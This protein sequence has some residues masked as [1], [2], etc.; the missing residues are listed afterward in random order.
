MVVKNIEHL[1]A[2]ACRLLENFLPVEGDEET[3]HRHGNDYGAALRYHAICSALSGL[4]E[5]LTGTEHEDSRCI[6]DGRLE[7]LLSH[8][9]RSDGV[10]AISREELDR[11]KVAAQAVLTS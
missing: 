6:I 9:F 5:A 11:F 3:A 10:P 8:P 1:V 2:Q 7:W 4:A